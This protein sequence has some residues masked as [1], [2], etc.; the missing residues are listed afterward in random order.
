MP[1]SIVYPTIKSQQLPPTHLTL[2]TVASIQSKYEADTFKKEV[3]AKRMRLGADSL[4]N[5]KFAVEKE[6]VLKSPVDISLHVFF[7]FLYLVGNHLRQVT[8]RIQKRIG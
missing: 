8:L 6:L 5:I 4:Q 3:E 7:N 2:L 1:E